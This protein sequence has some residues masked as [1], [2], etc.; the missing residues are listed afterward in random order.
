MIRILRMGGFLLSAVG[1][2]IASGIGA[3]ALALSFA[4][5]WFRAGLLWLVLPI[6]GGSAAALWLFEDVSTGGKVVNAQSNFAFVL[7]VYAI[8]AICGYLPGRIL[9]RWRGG[10]RG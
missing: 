2:Q 6:M 8:I 9:A 5:G 7:I 3:A 10:S 4:L 1:V